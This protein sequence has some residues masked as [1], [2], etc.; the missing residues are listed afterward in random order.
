MNASPCA[1][2]PFTGPTDLLKREL[3]E[4]WQGF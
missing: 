1:G 3:F 4:E 2:G